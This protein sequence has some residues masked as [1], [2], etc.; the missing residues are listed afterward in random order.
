MK[1]V[2]T[3]AT[4]LAF[5][6]SARAQTGSAIV[7]N[8]C[9]F[10]IFVQ[11]DF[12]KDP[13]S[14]PPQVIMSSMKTVSSNGAPWSETYQG[15][16][17]TGGVSIK[18][19]NSSEFSGSNIAQFEYTVVPES[20]Q[21][22]YDLSLINGQ[23]F[24]GLNSIL[25]PN[26]QVSGCSSTT[27][28]ASGG[29]ECPSGAT[30]CA[31]AYMNPD[32]NKA[33]SACALSTSVTY[34]LCGDSSGSTSELDTSSGSS[35]GSNSGSD[36]SSASSSASALPAPSSSSSLVVAPSSSSA[37]PSPSSSASSSSSPVAA[38]PA[39]SSASSIA[40]AVPS[41]Q[42]TTA[43]VIEEQ[44]EPDGSENVVVVY[45][46]VT[47]PYAAPQKRSHIH[48]HGHQRRSLH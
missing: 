8:N 3:A 7:V 12:T 5:I 43:A 2:A 28:T 45:E 48:R 9:D 42:T 37:A 46:T 23:Q 41:P 19:S 21:I 30:D 24:S 1:S 14:S 36:S 15:G 22:F 31:P 26:P 32:E 34:T 38:P 6:S 39:S 47:V 18:I 16:T 17:G 35:S 20:T 11:S 29:C 40:P 13:T 27:C 33:T 4:V 25:G 44:D 10:D